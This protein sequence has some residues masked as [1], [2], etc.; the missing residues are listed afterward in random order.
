MDHKLSPSTVLLLLVPP[1][2]WAGNAVVG[3]LVIEMIPPI[4]L[5]FLRWLI[6]AVFVIPLG[7]SVFKKGSGLWR[8]RR[9]YAM[10]GLL[11]IGL[12]N[13]LQYLALHSSTPINVTLVGASMPVWMLLIGM[14]FFRSRIA[15]RQLL[16][17]MLSLTGVLV[18]LGRG[19]WQ[20]LLQLRFVA[21]D[22]FMIVATI[23]WAFYSW[24]L[25]QSADTPEIRRNWATFLVAQLSFGVMWSG[26]FAAG[27]WALSSAAIE[28]SLPLGA[29]LLYVAVGP[30][31][32]AF[33]CWGIGVQRAGPATAGF[34]SNLTPLFAALM[35][36]AFLG[37][38]PHLYHAAAFA[39]IVGGIWFSTRR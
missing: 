11:G 6:A 7:Y 3:R 30:A 36:S 4:T 5:N 20:Q 29:A 8:L 1:L 35:S 31:I 14:L 27:E 26:L 21:G 10:L 39:L 25:V 18:V 13:G 16:G 12:Y 17:A 23:I 38:M 24:M 2:L 15:G 37:E 34:F 32:I 28:W 33:M 22:I 19:E 9:R